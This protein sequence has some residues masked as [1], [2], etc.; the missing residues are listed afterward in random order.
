MWASINVVYTKQDENEVN[1]ISPPKTFNSN[2]MKT[3]T[4]YALLIL[5]ISVAGIFSTKLIAQNNKPATV[6]PKT[7]FD[8]PFGNKVPKQ[9][10]LSKKK[11]I[12]TMGEDFAFD[13]KYEVTS[14][15][16]VFAPKKGMAAVFKANSCYITERMKNC[17]RKAKE[18]DIVI[19]DN[20]RAKGPG[21]VIT[22]APIIYQLSK[23]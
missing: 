2:L 10:L 4:K 17:I 1:Y 5:I 3:L 16:F 19:I 15:Q 14:F 18:N 12:A 20:I 7:N 21:G 11:I 6:K 22:L 23:D 8:V 9:V 13:V